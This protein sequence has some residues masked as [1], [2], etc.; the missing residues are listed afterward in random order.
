LVAWLVK[1][2]LLTNYQARRLLDGQG[3]RLTVGRYVILDRIGKG[4]MGRVY[5]ARH[6]L[7][8][9]VAALKFI[10]PEYLARPNAVRRFL[11]EM[12]L[13]GRLEHPN[14]VHAQDADQNGGVPYIVME[15]VPGQDLEQLVLTRGP[16]SPQEITHYAMQVAWGLAHAH[17]QGVIHRDIKPSNLLLGEDGRI[18]I[19]D[20]GLGALADADDADQGSFATCDGMVAGTADYMSPE[21]VVGRGTLDGRSDLYSLGCVMYFLLTGRVPFP[22][23]SKVECMASRIKGRP[24]ALGDVRPGL[25]AG[26]V[27]VVERLMANRPDD[28]Y[29]SAA[30]AAEALQACSE[31]EQLP[32]QS[33][34]RH[35]ASAGAANP[36]TLT[37][38]ASMP[39]EVSRTGS[40][41]I[42]AA[43]LGWWLSLL[44]Y[45]SGWS[46]RIA[47]LVVSAAVM[48]GSA[49]LTAAFIAGF[50][51]GGAPH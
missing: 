43:P 42:D 32:S 28:R 27:E 49:A 23:D 33:G 24:T 8:G 29:P 20:F 19:L 41:S 4:G 13:V 46:Q 10:A 2:D 51:I 22:G 12:R 6:R 11:R 14:I 17:S 45:L 7:L 36:G 30:T 48:T 31:C 1:K 38:E 39:G 35:S 16:L 44:W 50:A 15:Y 3:D 40:T 47:F 26:V 9:R 5:K 18:R 25:P 21:Q 37:A 34:A